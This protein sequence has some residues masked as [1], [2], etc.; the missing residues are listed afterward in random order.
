MMIN[1]NRLLTDFFRK[2][3][4]R[5][6]PATAP[7]RQI[8]RGA[9]RTRAEQ[10]VDDA[11]DLIKHGLT[12]EEALDIKESLIDLYK[13]HTSE[14][15]KKPTSFSFVARQPTQIALALI[16]LAKTHPECFLTP[17]EQA[18][19]AQDMKDIFALN[20][21]KRPYVQHPASSSDIAWLVREIC[22]RRV[23]PDHLA[24]REASQILGK[25]RQV[26]PAPEFGK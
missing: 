22:S 14:Y 12:A 6:I 9:L 17:K 21:R 23:G 5:T 19:I 3:N 8:P 13:W 16:E 10:A 2:A 4:S 25:L 24:A 15:L 20:N 11:A 18:E 1:K 7:V 26:E